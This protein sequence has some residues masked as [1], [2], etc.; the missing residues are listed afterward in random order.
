MRSIPQRRHVIGSWSSPSSEMSRNEI[1]R[2]LL[3]SDGRN[4]SQQTILQRLCI[5][6]PVGQNRSSSNT[7]NTSKTAVLTTSGLLES[8]HS[9]HIALKGAMCICHHQPTPGHVQHHLG[10]DPSQ[11]RVTAMAHGTG[12]KKKSDAI[13]IQYAFQ[14]SNAD[15]SRSMK[16]NED[17]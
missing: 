15:Q 9:H 7:S 2:T 1:H 5:G 11:S 12:G 3:V 14:T 17:Q 8:C 13:E 6:Y 4:M 16:I 10:V